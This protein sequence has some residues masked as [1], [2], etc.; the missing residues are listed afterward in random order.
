MY[1]YFLKPRQ[2]NG[3]LDYVMTKSG[4]KGKTLNLSQIR[5]S[6]GQQFVQGKR[7]ERQLK[8][9][10]AEGKRKRGITNFVEGILTDL[11]TVSY[12]LKSNM[13]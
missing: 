11:D 10:E 6:I 9:L 8:S 1:G 2:V 4:A 3:I 13:E 5:S 7:P 12:L